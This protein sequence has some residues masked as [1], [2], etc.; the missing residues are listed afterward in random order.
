MKAGFYMKARYKILTA[1]TLGAASFGGTLLI[2]KLVKVRALSKNILKNSDSALESYSWRLGNIVYRKAGSGSPL[3][4]LHDL[5]PFSSFSEWDRIFSPLSSR[6]AVFAPDLIGCGRSEKPNMTYTNFVYVQMI[7]DF[8][9]NIIGR[10]TKVIASGSIVPALV[11][12]AKASPELFDNLIFVSPEHP[13][14]WALFPGRN[15]KTHKFIMETPVV[16]TLLY[17][18][19]VSRRNIVKNHMFSRFYHPQFFSDSFLDL[20][21]ELS[22]T[23]FAP[24]ALYASISGNFTKFNIRDALANLNLSICILSGMESELLRNAAVKYASL[25]PSIETGLISFSK[26]YPHLENPEEF[27]RNLA[28]YL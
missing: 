7:C 19:C 1:L 16:G 14:D 11:M 22:H 12:A 27:L 3:L 15:A 20:Y 26:N 6:Y 24:K 5:T 18:I 23:G 4:L 9:R 13:D 28:I 8:I 25:N 17:H 10:R 2:N 21:T